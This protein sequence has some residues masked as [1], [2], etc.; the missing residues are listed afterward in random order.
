[1]PTHPSDAP[2]APLSSLMCAP[3]SMTGA[4][5]QR[6]HQH[7]TEIPLTRECRPLSTACSPGHRSCRHCTKTS[8]TGQGLTYPHTSHLTFGGFCCHDG[9]LAQLDGVTKRSVGCQL[10]SCLKLSRIP[11]YQHLNGRS[12]KETSWGG[13]TSESVVLG[14]P[15]HADVLGE[16]QRGSDHLWPSDTQVVIARV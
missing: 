5:P 3:S 16:K 2:S 13:F 4:E 10:I 15:R 11:P 14:A 1:M 8:C 6:Y 7:H 9:F 12:P